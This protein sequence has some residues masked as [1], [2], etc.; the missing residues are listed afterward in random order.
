[1]QREFDWLD[2]EWGKGTWETFPLADWLFHDKVLLYQHDLYDQTMTTDREILTWNLAYGFMLSYAWDDR[3]DTLSSPW[4]GLV[5]DF[6]RALGP[7]YAGVAL[8][9]YKAVAEDVTETRFGDFSILANWSQA[10][11]YPVD[12][13]GLAPQGFIARA[14]DGSV[15]AGAF[16][17]TFG[18][19]ALSP[20]VHY[21]VVERTQ[22]AETVRQP[23]GSDTQLAVDPPPV[24]TAGRSI[25]ATAIAADGSAIADVPGELRGSHYA[26]TYQ[27]T[28]N[29]IPVDSYRLTAA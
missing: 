28:L 8:T 27:A 2:E 14:D 1:M 26:F 11:S 16:T 4:L 25:R 23:I 7:H 19:S 13:Y 29:G 12:G 21:V 9:S 15:I 22:D 6:Q 3:H 5:A 17:D 18:A 20:G 24:W 10:A